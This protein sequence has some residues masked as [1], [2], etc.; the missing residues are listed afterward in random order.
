MARRTSY[1]CPRCRAVVTR[2]QGV[3]TVGETLEILEPVGIRFYR[4][5]DD[6]TPIGVWGACRCGHRWRLR[7]VS[8]VQGVADR[9]AYLRRAD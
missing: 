1:T 2:F 6:F 5:A 4:D 8:D 9:L 3:G 7:G